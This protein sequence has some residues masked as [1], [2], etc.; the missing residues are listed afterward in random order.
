MAQTKV[1]LLEDDPQF[2]YLIQ[3]YAEASG[4]LLIHAANAHQALILAQQNP[5][6]LIL[7]DIAPGTL[8]NGWQILGD[9]KLNPIT[10]H[11]PAYICSAND[12]VMHLWID[13]ADGFLVKPVMYEDFSTIL[14]NIMTERGELK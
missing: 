11:I 2:V 5:P 6:D 8:S 1:L 14:S 4:C 10:S 13:R 3:R 9:L 12:T 7:I